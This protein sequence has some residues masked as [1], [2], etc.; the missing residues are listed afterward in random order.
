MEKPREKQ[1][2]AP[3][4]WVKVENRKNCWVSLV[5]VLAQDPD[6]CD[7]PAAS[8]SKPVPPRRSSDATKCRIKWRDAL[9]FLVKPAKMIVLG[10]A[11][12]KQ[13]FCFTAN[14]WANYLQ[15]AWTRAVVSS[16]IVI[17]AADKTAFNELK[18]DMLVKAVGIKVWEPPGHNPR[19]RV[20][21]V[22]TGLSRNCQGTCGAYDVAK[23]VCLC[24]DSSRS[25]ERW[26]K[27]CFQG[28]V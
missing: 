18:T 23:L 24:K 22:P 27:T 1:Q 15:I 8:P 14:P 7:V 13:R 12:D 20:K 16:A 11:V 25:S 10:T 2:D 3:F 6:T 28:W 17:K 4:L 9:T 19:V 5:G 21:D 26:S